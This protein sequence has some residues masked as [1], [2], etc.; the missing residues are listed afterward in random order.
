VY[1]WTRGKRATRIHGEFVQIPPV[2]SP[3]GQL[4]ALATESLWLENRQGGNRLILAP[5]TPRTAS[6]II[7]VEWSP[8]GSRLMFLRGEGDLRIVPVAGGRSRLVAKDVYRAAWSP[9]GRRI[10]YAANCDVLPGDEW[11]CRLL[12]D[13]HK[14][15]KRKTLPLHRE[16]HVARMGQERRA[17]PGRLNRSWAWSSYRRPTHRTRTDCNT[18]LA[19]TRADNRPSTRSP[20]ARPHPA[21]RHHRPSLARVNHLDWS[22]PDKDRHSSRVQH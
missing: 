7:G 5:G 10:A 9:D 11:I 18:R 3:D 20:Q 13:L 12:R 6:Y 17:C 2:W 21:T 15:R 8:D 1:V 19:R 4:L 14:R 22:D 16:G